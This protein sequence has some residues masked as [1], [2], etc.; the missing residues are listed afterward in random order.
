MVATEKGYHDETVGHLIPQM[1]SLSVQELHAL[2]GTPVGA[3]SCQQLMVVPSHPIPFT[4]CLYP[5]AFR[6]I[7]LKLPQLTESDKVGLALKKHMAVQMC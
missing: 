3:G 1:P 5:S 4:F 6:Y 2:A 7:I